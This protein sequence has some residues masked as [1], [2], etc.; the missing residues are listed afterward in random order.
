MYVANKQDTRL[1]FV[2]PLL[3]YNEEPMYTKPIHYWMPTL[4]GWKILANVSTNLYNTLAGIATVY[5]S[6]GRV[7]LY[8]PHPEDRVVV[9]GVIR[10]YLGHSMTN[11]IL[12][13]NTYVF[14]YFGDQ[15]EYGYNWWIIRRSVAWAAQ[16]PNED[17]PILD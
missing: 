12:P 17:L 7:V 1:G 16:I 6:S 5:N 13:F 10:E 11:F 14:N 3:W 15:L 9:N 4:S 2:T 8:G